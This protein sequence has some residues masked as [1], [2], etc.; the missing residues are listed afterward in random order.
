MGHKLENRVNVIFNGE[1]TILAFNHEGEITYKVFTTGEPQ[2]NLEYV[3][4]E[5]KN[6]RDRTTAESGSNMMYWYKNYFLV[7]GYQRIRNTMLSNEDK[8]NVFYVN[9]IAF[10]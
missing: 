6:T 7:Y 10:N 9:K 1:E 2:Q 4:I 3:T 8:R 5:S